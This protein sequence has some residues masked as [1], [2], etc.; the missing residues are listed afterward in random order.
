MYWLILPAIVVVFFAII[1]IRTLRFTPPAEKE[2]A[3]APVTL[4]E[5][6]IV[7]DMAAMI[8]CRTVS[9]HDESLVD[10]DEFIR[11][12][13]VLADRFPLIHEKATL[14]K[15]GKTGLLYHLKGESTAAPSV[16]MSH[17][18]VVPVDESG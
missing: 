7:D 6:K 16:C 10:W 11:F 3:A 8:R 18:D 1:L 17:Y 15:L 2:V 9:S 5:E 13:Q 4:N 14:T 12:Q